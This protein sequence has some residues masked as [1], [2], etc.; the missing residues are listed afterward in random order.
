MIGPGTFDLNDTSK[1]YRDLTKPMGA[2]YRKRLEQLE[3]RRK[4]VMDDAELN[5]LYSTHYSSE[6]IV[7]SYHIRSEPFTTY[8]IQFQGTN[9]ITLNLLTSDIHVIL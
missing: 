1:T 5:Y 6:A 4:Q 3:Q 8:A 7:L 9:Y 2:L